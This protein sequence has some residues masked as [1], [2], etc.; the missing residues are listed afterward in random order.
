MYLVSTALLNA[1]YPRPGPE[2]L[3]CK[4]QQQ[5]QQQGKL[6]CSMYRRK[7][8]Q[9]GSTYARSRISSEAGEI[10]LAD[11]IDHMFRGNNESNGYSSPLMVS[12]HI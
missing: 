5:Q 3:Q 2:S 6:V 9:V 8:M 4:E 10:S 12:F 11:V 7:A 1:K